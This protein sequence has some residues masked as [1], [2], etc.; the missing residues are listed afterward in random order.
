LA[1]S[2]DLTRQRLSLARELQDPSLEMLV[3]ENFGT[4]AFWRGEFSEALVSLREALSRYTTEGGRAVRLFYGTDT[5]VVCIAYEAQALLFLGLLEQALQK[6][7]ESVA[8]ARRL[9]H[10][11]SLVLALSFA[12]IVHLQR[13]ELREAGARVEEASALACEQQLSQWIAS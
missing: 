8:T 10:V 1:T 9:G 13:G 4:L 7:E 6:A 11:H 12:G 2:I 5:A 3:H